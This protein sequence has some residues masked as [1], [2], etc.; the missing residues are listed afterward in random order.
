MHVSSLF[1]PSELWRVTQERNTRR[2]NITFSGL[3]SN[4]IFFLT[5]QC[6]R[7][8]IGQNI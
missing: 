3:S 6:G 8:V 4:P 5:P 1:P 7:I 2:I